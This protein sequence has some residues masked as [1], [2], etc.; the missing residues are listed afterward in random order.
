MLG[1]ECRSGGESGA[2]E[3]GRQAGWEEELGG[4]E[5]AQHTQGDAGGAEW[6]R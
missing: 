1:D 5:L 3:F 4:R 6:V 2:E